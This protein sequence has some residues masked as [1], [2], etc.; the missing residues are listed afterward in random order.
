V[1][2]EPARPFFFSATVCCSPIRSI[3]HRFQALGSVMLGEPITTAGAQ[4][5]REEARRRLD[6]ALMR[7]RLTRIGIGAGIALL[8]A[9]GFVWTDLDARVDNVKVPGVVQHVGPLATKNAAD[10]LSVD[11]KLDTGQL[12]TLMV[13]KTSDPHVGDRVEIVEHRHHTGRVTY[14]WK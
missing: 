3:T 11:V 4:D 13:L 5:M 10:G 8:V 2:D 12:K 6:R 7:T 9:A 1:P 14:T